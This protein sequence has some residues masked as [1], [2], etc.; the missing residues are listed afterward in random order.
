MI[1]VSFLF[2]P[3]SAPTSDSPP[4]PSINR[5]GAG[6]QSTFSEK[7]LC[8]SRKRLRLHAFLLDFDF[9]TCFSTTQL[10]NDIRYTWSATKA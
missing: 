7:L 5:L 3:G 4:T 2:D 1:I 10:L 9:S 6:L 8:C